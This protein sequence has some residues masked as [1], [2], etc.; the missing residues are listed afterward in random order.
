MQLCIG[1]DVI[2]F[3]RRENIIHN[4]NWRRF[5][6]S[7]VALVTTST[8]S[9]NNDISE[10][11]RLTG[12]KMISPCARSQHCEYDECGIKLVQQVAKWLYT[13]RI[14]RN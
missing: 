1:K 3:V 14:T 9:R 6:V 4:R 12:R 5:N 7:Y 10:E 13:C 11:L 2:G 8:K